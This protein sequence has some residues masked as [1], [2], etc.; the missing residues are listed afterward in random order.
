MVFTSDVSLKDVPR[1]DGQ[2]PLI[3]GCATRERS[4][5]AHG[6]LSRRRG[7]VDPP[8]RCRTWPALL[9][10]V[11]HGPQSRDSGVESVVLSCNQGVVAH[12]LYQ[13]VGNQ[14][15]LSG[16]LRQSFGAHHL[17]D[18]KLLGECLDC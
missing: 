10:S 2:P 3:A 11:G 6:E 8:T 14:T 7:P 18:S 16:S 17:D 13:T 12:A 5:P 9:G 4:P 15:H 1:P